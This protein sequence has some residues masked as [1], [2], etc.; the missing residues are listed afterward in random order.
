MAKAADNKV[1]GNITVEGARIGFKN[2]SGKE[3]KYN[4]AGDR[5][6]C[7]FLDDELAA[8]LAGDGW[9]VK[10]LTPRDDEEEPQ[11]YIQVKVKFGN[12][13]PPVIYLV[14]GEDKKSMTKLGED[15]VNILDW[16]EISN[17]DLIVRPYN[18]KISNKEGVKT[19]VTAYLKTMYVTIVEDKLAAKY[20]D[21]PTS[22]QSAMIGLE[23]EEYEE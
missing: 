20:R 8:R 15:E 4:R 13:L 16:A 1:K 10:H 2:F 7:L 6:F 5:N 14:K 3:S 17:V 19:G 18:W 22:A 21:V 23:E 11:A 9:N 12:I